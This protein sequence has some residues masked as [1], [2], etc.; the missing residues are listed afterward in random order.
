MVAKISMYTHVNVF[1]K[2]QASDHDFLLILLVILYILQKL[3][4]SLLNFSLK[5]I[6]LETLM[7]LVLYVNEKWMSVNRFMAKW[8]MNQILN[9]ISLTVEITSAYENV[10]MMHVF[11]TLQKVRS[12]SYVGVSTMYGT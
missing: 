2:R 5:L 3:G 4:I 11:K 10:F 6:K 12:V 9:I 7:T 8:S 1:N